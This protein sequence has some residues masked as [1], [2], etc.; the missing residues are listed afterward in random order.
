VD[1]NIHFEIYNASQTLMT[2]YGGSSL[3]LKNGVFYQ[4]VNSCF[5]GDKLTAP[6]N[7][8]AS[9]RDGAVVL[10]W[11]MEQCNEC[12]F[13]VYRDGLLYDIADE[14]SYSDVNHGDEFHVY[15]ITAFN[16]IVESDPSNACNI[17]PESDCQHP[18]NLRYHIEE[19]NKILLSWNPVV[20]ASGYKVYRR[21]QGGE[22]SRVKL[23]SQTSC[24]LGF[25][26]MPCDLY[27]FAVTAYFAQDHC[28]SSFASTKA[29]PTLNFVE[30]NNTVIP[31]RLDAD[32]NEDGV[33]LVWLNAMMAEAHKVY[34]NGTCIAF[35]VSGNSYLDVDVEVGQS[36]CYTVVGENGQVSSNH[37]NEICVDWATMEVETAAEQ[38]VTVYPNPAR[39][40]VYVSAEGLKYLEVA[41]LLGQVVMTSVVD[42]DSTMV[43]LSSLKQGAYFL[44]VVS[45]AGNTTVKFVKL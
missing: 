5:E 25:S 21:P 23:T 43:D 38:Q 2:I 24:E 4:A 45:D 27:E 32:V 18:T 10:S 30:V 44:R 19:G 31:M 8:T 35:G 6:S 22:F 12:S 34:R 41:N 15:R 16:G 3:N 37:S 42:E 20:G 17:Q 40:Q 11:E 14:A 29:D 1:D 7:L 39:D 9:S 28:E 13:L 33:R 26:A 36:Y